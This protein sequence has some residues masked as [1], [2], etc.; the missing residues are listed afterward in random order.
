MKVF[1]MF[2]TVHPGLT[3][4]LKIKYQALAVL[5]SKLPTAVLINTFSDISFQLQ[6]ALNLQE[7]SSVTSD[8]ILA[9]C[10]RF[11]GFWHTDHEFY[12]LYRFLVSMIF[13]SD[14]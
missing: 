12:E 4:M 1:Q 14:L 7:I 11:E 9:Y 8:L 5:V 2:D 10:L 3:W 13:N 6:A